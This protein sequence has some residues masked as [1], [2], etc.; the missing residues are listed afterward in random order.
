M[1]FGFIR[2]HKKRLK[3]F[4]EITKFRLIVLAYINILMAFIWP[5]MVQFYSYLEVNIN[6]FIIHTATIISVFGILKTFGEKMVK[7]ISN[8]FS[9][10]RIFLIIII[11]DVFMGIGILFYFVSIKTMLWIDLCISTIQLPFF[12]AYSNSLNNYLTYFQKEDFTF[13]QN[14]RAD[15]NAETRLL[16]LIL[17]GI[18]TLLS[19]KIAILIFVCGILIL[20]VYQFSYYKMFKKYDFKYLLNYKRNLKRKEKNV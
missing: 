11:L 5:I 4:D 3:K 19:I 15:L 18:I 7:T 16:G 2:F 6:D 14:Y 12:L 1:K 20:S 8:N 17:A 9:F 10:S 13:F